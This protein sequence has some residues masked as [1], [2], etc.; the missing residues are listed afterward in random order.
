MTHEL[1]DG[2]GLN[3]S[4]G[5]DGDQ[6]FRVSL[7]HSPVEGSG[8]PAVD[9]MN[10]TDAGVV[11]EIVVE[12]FAG[13]I[14]GT[15]VNNDHAKAGEVRSQHGGDGLH[16]DAFFVVGG[17]QDGDARRRLRHYGIVG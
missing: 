7:R 13:A 17:N 12:Q 8:F 16:D 15:V 14:G 9:L 10:Q 2:V 3:F 5:V 6:D 4:V 11:A 1:A